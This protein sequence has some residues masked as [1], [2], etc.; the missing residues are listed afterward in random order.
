[1]GLA[2]RWLNAIL[3]AMLTSSGA[4]Q[5]QEEKH[6]V[7]LHTNDLHGTVE[8]WTGW[9]E[10]LAGRTI[11]GLAGVAGVVEQVRAAE[12]AK[13]V[14][15]LSAGDDIGDSMIVDLTQGQALLELMAATR[16]DARAMGNHEP[17]FGAAF[18][19]EPG[20]A[21]PLLAA[22]VRRSSGE[23]LGRPYLVVERAGLRVGILGLA[24]PNTP[25]TTARSHVAGLVFDRDSAGVVRTYLPR[26]RAEGAQL[27]VVLSHLGLSADQKLAAQVPGIDVIVGGHS[28]NRMQQ[29]KRVGTTLIVQA[30]AHGSDVGRLDLYFDGDGVLRHRRELITVDHARIRPDARVAALAEQLQAPHRAALTETVGTAAAS[31]VRAQTIAGEEP[32][33]RDAESPAD[34]LFAD[35]IRQETDS[36]IALLPGVGYGIALQP[37]PISAAALRNL[38]PHES[39]VVTLTLSGAQVRTILEQSLENVFT[40]KTTDKVGGMIQVS[41]IRFAFDAGKPRGQ[42]L[43]SIRRSDGDWDEAASYRVATNSLLAQGGHNYRTFEQATN[44]TEHGSQ[45]DM[46]K[47]WIQAHSPV[48]APEPGRIERQ[49]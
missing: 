43:R 42:R 9:E 20:D 40:S 27:I 26:M 10:E 19:A 21:V 7:L 30:G 34:S 48:T 49:Q 33:K 12:G 38:V 18:L 28:H 31:I 17:D 39:R 25:L 22:N 35:I 29:A 2:P 24:Y 14:L 11:G 45:Y 41:G 47:R 4:A 23:P 46:I 8:P 36:D 37:G 16:Y 32:E 15:L 44:K 6:L 5:A 1:M 3:L 13:N